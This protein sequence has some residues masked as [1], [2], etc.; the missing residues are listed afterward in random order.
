[1]RAVAG[2]AGAVPRHLRPYFPAAGSTLKSSGAAGDYRKIRELVCELAG[3]GGGGG[4][5]QKT[6]WNEK[7]VASGHPSSPE[8]HEGCAIRCMR[9]HGHSLARGRPNTAHFAGSAGRWEDPKA[10][11][12]LTRRRP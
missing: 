12:L 1:V 4:K 2:G 11:P 5:W 8:K 7:G 10:P 9:Q 6:E 3:A